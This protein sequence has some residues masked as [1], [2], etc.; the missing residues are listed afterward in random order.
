M[1]RSRKLTLQA[2]TVAITL[3]RVHTLPLFFF[4]QVGEVLES[5]DAVLLVQH[6]G[7]NPMGQVAPPMTGCHVNGSAPIPLLLP[8]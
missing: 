3:V 1:Q 2:D 6:P 4:L 5:T 7:L 8:L